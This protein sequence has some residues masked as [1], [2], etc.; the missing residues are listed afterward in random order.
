MENEDLIT[1]NVKITIGGEPLAIEL[2]VPSKPVK[3][4]RMLP[5]FQGMSN[6]FTELGEKAAAA[7]GA[8]ISCK[9]GCGACCRQP[10]P[11]AEIETHQIA[12]LVE[13]MPE[14]RRGEI[15]KRFERAWHHFTEIGWFDRLDAAAHAAHQERQ[16]IAAE[17]FRENVPCPFL[18]DE[19]CSIHENRPLVCREYL[20]TSPVEHCLA[21]DGKQ[22]KMVPLPA[23]PSETVRRITNS[24]NLN[25]VVN[26]VPLVLALEWARRFPDQSPEKT[27]EQWMAMFF[28]SLTKSEIPEA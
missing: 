14:P 4:G 18:E 15:K 8:K 16:R 9:K 2:T 3:P 11:L 27:G 28:T 24:Q 21:L 17:Y 13:A 5:V 20:V 26:F 19:S 22:I 23:K 7:A 6:L 25:R 10:V 12:A 1:G